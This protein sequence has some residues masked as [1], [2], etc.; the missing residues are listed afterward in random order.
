MRLT[1]TTWN[2][3]SVRL[4][5]D[6][7]ARFVAD[8]A[9]DVLCLQETKCPDDQFPLAAVKAMGFRHWAFAGQKGYNGV[10]IF[11]RFPLLDI[12]KQTFGGVEQARHIAAMLGDEAGKAA[13]LIV[14]NFYVPAGG[15]I[16]DREVNPKF[17]HKLDFLSDMT[18]WSTTGR[19]NRKKSILV[20][21]LNIA[22]YET[23]VWSHKALLDVVSHTPVE[24]AGLE[25]MR[26]A[27][28][29]IDAVR[30]VKPEPE[31][32]YSWWSYRSPDWSAADKG[33]RLDH[34]W[35][36]ADLGG[37]IS[38]AEV[39]RHARGWDKPS[40]HAPVTVQLEF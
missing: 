24:T 14:H 1:L 7:V 9:P 20:G 5:I 39:S 28:G 23:D 12:E 6:L 11:S 37:S 29:W 25:A 15:D 33:R 8:H 13:G 10:A 17:G 40:D 36:T 30:Q 22:P 26:R 31:R 2:I 19:D 3:N 38:T 21:D 4:R 27:G 18:T 34:V 35:S 32:V 16:A